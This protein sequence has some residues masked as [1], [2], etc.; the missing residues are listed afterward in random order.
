[1]KN[2]F[3]V[4]ANMNGDQNKVKQKRIKWFSWQVIDN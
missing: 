1:M 2:I 4:Y 3:M